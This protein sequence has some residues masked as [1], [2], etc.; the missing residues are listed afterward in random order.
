MSSATAVPV[1]RTTVLPRTALSVAAVLVCGGLCLG[2]YT[3]CGADLFAGFRVYLC[4]LVY[5][6][7]PGW[8]LAHR[9]VPDKPG[10]RPLCALLCGCALL[11]VCYLGAMVLHQPLILRL[12]PPALLCVLLWL[13]GGLAGVRC[14]ARDVLYGLEGLFTRHRALLVLWAVLCVFSA[15]SF[16]AVNPHPAAAGAVSLD[17]DFLWNVGNAEAFCKAFPAQDIR[18]AGVRFSYHYLTELLTAALSL[19]SGASCYD[20]FAFFLPPV[21]LAGEIAA[22]YWLGLVIYKESTKAS[23]IPFVLFCFQCGSLWKVF[24]T[25][26]SIFGNT[27]LRHL[28]SN[29]NAQASAVV[30]F[31]IFLGLF[32][33]LAKARFGG[34]VRLW[35]LCLVAFALFAVAKGPEAILALCACGAAMV[36][37]LL[38]QKPRYP[39]AVLFLALLAGLFALIYHI[40]YAAG[41]NTSMQF[42]IFCLRNTLTYAR[43]EPLADWLCTHLPISGYVWLVLIGVIDTFFFCPFQF[44]LWG[45]SLPGALRHLPRLDAAHLLLHAG[46]VGGFL[47]Y[48]LFSHESSSQVYFAL[49][50][51]LCMSIL[52]AEQ[53]PGLRRTKFPPLITLAAGAAGLLT[54][55]CMVLSLSGR[56]LSVL[57]QLPDGGLYTPAAVTAGDEEAGRWLREN[58]PAGTVFLTNRT[59]GLPT[60]DLDG[61]DGI[62]NVYTAFS[63]VQCYM[64]GWTYAMSNMGV[65]A[66]MVEHRRAVVDKV[67]DAH[68]PAADLPPLCREEGVTCLVWAKRWPGSAPAGQTPA[69]ENADVAIYWVG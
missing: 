3:L 6:L 48:H 16:S 65:P 43:L 60:P 28:T 68:T 59:S 32:A 10:L 11:L 5:L 26:D 69:F 51:M 30:F 1:R 42:S 61:Q 55:L 46:T 49:F 47:A 41:A 4:L 17:R 62:S 7:A 38:F 21:W 27:M 57:S 63:G 35:G 25:G 37:V 13:R 44:C 22:L 2:I 20:L 24:R 39:L 36:F 19:V 23:Y 58:A 50:A 31:S 40:L 45:R 29:I 9:L 67:F 8:L 14:T 15:L 53:L 18:F 66:D 56:G 52:A 34:G 54:A 33:C 64:E 12:G